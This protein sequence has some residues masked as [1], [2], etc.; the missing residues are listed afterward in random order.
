[1]SLDYRTRHDIEHGQPGRNLKFPMALGAVMAF[2]LPAFLPN[3]TWSSLLWGLFAGLVALGASYKFLTW[4]RS[5]GI[6]ASMIGVTI[7]MGTTIVPMAVGAIMTLVKL[8]VE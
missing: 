7:L 6:P 5:R 4:S 1:M 8:M 2:L 3:P